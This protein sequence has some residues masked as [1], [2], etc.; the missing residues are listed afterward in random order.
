MTHTNHE[1]Y[2][3]LQVYRQ[4][5]N[6]PVDFTSKVAT[7]ASRI[8][9]QAVSTAMTETGM[10]AAD[11]EDQRDS[12]EPIR[13]LTTVRSPAFD[14]YRPTDLRLLLL[15]RTVSLAL[16][17]Y[18]LNNHAGHF[19]GQQPMVF[20]PRSGKSVPSGNQSPV[21]SGFEKI[22]AAHDLNPRRLIVKFDTI[23]EIHDRGFGRELA[24]APKIGQVASE[25]LNEES[26]YCQDALEKLA[27][28]TAN[29]SASVST[30]VPFMQV[31]SLPPGSRQKERFVELLY[32]PEMNI[33]PVVLVLGPMY[34]NSDTIAGTGS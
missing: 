8:F 27:Q 30:V 17:G 15:R 11:Y 18:N 29:P 34:A 31:P 16:S 3:Y 25:S 28:R 6:N 23:H 5:V 24:L 19:T 32:D 20:K 21:R 2:R 26:D 1:G 12:L 13:S 9:G 33:L 10:A 7:L 4:V 22:S 14:V